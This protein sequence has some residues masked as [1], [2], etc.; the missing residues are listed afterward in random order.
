MKTFKSINKWIISGYKPET[1]LNK[2][3]HIELFDVESKEYVTKFKAPIKYKKKIIELF[4]NAINESEFG[5]WIFIKKR[6]LNVSMIISLLTSL[7]FFNYLSS[8]IFKIEIKG[9]YPSFE[10]TLI[11]SLEDNN[12]L[13]YKKFPISSELLAI[14]E[15]LLEKHYEE[16]EFL[17]IRRSGSTLKI[18]YNK[19]RKSI[20]LPKPTNSIYAKKDGIIKQIL[21][22]TGVVEVSINQ[23]V[24]E[25]DLLINDTIIDNN[26]NEIY[27]GCAGKI[28]AYTWYLYEISYEND[29]KMT[30]DEVFIYLLD[31]IRNRVNENIDGEDEYI[32][33]E[34]VL[35]FIENASTI[36]LKVHYTLVEDITR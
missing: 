19:R 33:K 28:Y 8:L 15:T 27:I 22:K 23:F 26:N 18:K 14:E 12:L 21:V 6:I 32:E 5:I 11:N 20:E 7:I 31:E 16:I 9:D 1:V 2:L 30:S 36:T 4:P 10:N 25:G 3:N 17:E 34:N 13:K 29:K 24:K 35:Q